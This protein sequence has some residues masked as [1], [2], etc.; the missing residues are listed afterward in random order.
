MSKKRKK[1]KRK[2]EPALKTEAVPYKT[3]PGRELVVIALVTAA[4]LG[5]FVVRLVVFAGEAVF[6]TDECF[7]A[8]RAECISH[9]NY[10]GRVGELYSGYLDVSPPFFHAVGGLGILLFGKGS[11]PYVNIFLFAVLAAG[12][13]YF[14]ARFMSPL[15]AACALLGFVTSNL[16]PHFALVFY[17]EMITTIVF[18]GTLLFLYLAYT[19][20]ERKYTVL[21]GVFLGLLLLTKQTAMAMPPILMVFWVYLL[22]KRDMANVKKF[23]VF[24]VIAF[25]LW[26]P[27]LVQK[28]LA[29]GSP[30]HPFFTPIASDQRFAEL[31]A[32]KL[33]I[34]PGQMFEDI[35][36]RYGLICFG[37]ALAALLFLAYRILVKR[38][39]KGEGL[40]LFI[41][42]S[43]FMIFVFAGIGSARHFMQF[44]P[45][46]CL[47]GA[48]GIFLLLDKLSLQPLK[49]VLTGIIAVVV[50]VAVVNLPNYRRHVNC[51]PVLM[52][53]YQFIRNNDRL[54][55]ALVMSVWTYSTFYYS[56]RRT[57]WPHAPAVDSPIELYF[58]KSPARFHETCKKK[59]INYILVD[60]SKIGEKPDSTNYPEPFIACIET[61]VKQGKASDFYPPPGPKSYKTIETNRG[62]MKV[63]SV[64]TPK[65]TYQYLCR[66]TRWGPRA[67]ISVYKI[68]IP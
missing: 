20:D 34:A 46:F 13:F 49:Y 30:F 62:P 58:E 22:V 28:F 16:V 47:F 29:T 4:I 7:H 41:I 3:G 61:L 21:A 5:A 15:L 10:P 24:G 59:K 54:E 18:S 37:L 35:Y 23:L 63:M 6:F 50:I 1:K 51:R 8:F 38:I 14:A 52:N 39:A 65:A 40:L 12:G 60:Y 19:R 2:M 31:Q 43:S 33:F 64:N 11:L 66:D 32:R 55:D 44:L 36:T 53:A 48:I 25:A 42:I 68:H 56:G 67:L 57:T 17:Q 27:R 45:V 9:L 26:L